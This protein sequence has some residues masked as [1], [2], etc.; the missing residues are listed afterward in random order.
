MLQWR[1]DGQGK[2][3]PGLPALPCFSY[4]CKSL[5]R[6][7]PCSFLVLGAAL[8]GGVSRFTKGCWPGV[9]LGELGKLP[10]RTRGLRGW[11]CACECDHTLADLAS[12]E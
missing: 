1:V 10:W 12:G 2:G 7:G 9:L 4:L 3:K 5:R 6:V 11:T 8:C